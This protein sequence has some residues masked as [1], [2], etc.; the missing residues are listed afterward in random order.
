VE[1]R[2]QRIRSPSESGKK[3]KT[4]QAE[5][6]CA[7]LRPPAIEMALDPTEYFRAEHAG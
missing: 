3:V 7:Y 6:R 2:C 5:L 1:N 4:A